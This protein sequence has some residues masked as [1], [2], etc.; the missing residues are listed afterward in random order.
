MQSTSG[1]VP[2]GEGSFFVI[3]NTACQLAQ[4]RNLGFTE[5]ECTTMA[6]N[7]ASFSYVEVIVV[8]T[9]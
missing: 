9:S 2:A 4:Q 6:S 8:W 1:R 5:F 3:E 7:P